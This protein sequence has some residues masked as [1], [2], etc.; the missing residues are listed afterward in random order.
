MLRLYPLHLICWLYNI[1]SVHSYGRLSSPSVSSPLFYCPPPFFLSVSHPVGFLHST[2]G[3]PT[4]F[5][6]FPVC[7]GVRPPSDVMPSCSPVFSSGTIEAWLSG[8]LTD[9]HAKTQIYGLAGWGHSFQLVQSHSAEMQFRSKKSLS[10]Y[11]LQFWKKTIFKP[12][13]S[14]YS[15]LIKFTTS[16]LRIFFNSTKK[17]EV[18]TVNKQIHTS[19]QFS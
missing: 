8:Q 6:G 7:W 15:L 13:N 17:V 2:L 1:F 16:H 5:Q 18:N 4:E 12:N 10:G 3:W 11:A 9:W 19:C 14:L